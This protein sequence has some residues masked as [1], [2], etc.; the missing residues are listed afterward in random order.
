MQVDGRT[1]TYRIFVP[2]RPK[3]PAPL[4]F[5]F[6]GGFGTGARGE[7]DRIRRRGGERGFVAVYP[8]GL[9]RAWNARPCCGASS[10]LGVDDVGFV[11]KLLDRLGRQ[12]PIDRKRIY[13]TGISNGGLFSYRL[14]CELSGRIAAAASVAATLISRCSPS[15][16]SRSSTCT[17]WKTRTSRSRADR[18]RGVVDLEWPA[19]QDGIER[20]RTLDGCP[21][22]AKTTVSGAVTA[23]SWA[24][25]LQRH[26]GPAGDDRRPWPRG[27][28]AVQRDARDLALLRRSPQA[29][30]VELAGYEFEAAPIGARP[31]SPSDASCEH[32]VAE[33]VRM[34]RRIGLAALVVGLAIFAAGS[35]AGGVSTATPRAT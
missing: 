28:G 24:P 3:K 21:A 35:S 18:G 34:S 5:V 15:R 14:A 2:A 1:R 27:Q 25:C 33:V 22:T 9:G 23:S 32:Q 31:D 11:A 13:A 17:G 20:W 30:A 19:A 7:P 29:L 6:H 8:D 12:Y 10:R 26:R 16:P 4:V